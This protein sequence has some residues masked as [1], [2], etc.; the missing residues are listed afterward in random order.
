MLSLLA[1]ARED[2][3]SGLDP[4]SIKDSCLRR[5]DKPSSYLLGIISDYLFL[6]ITF[7]QSDGYFS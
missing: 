6:N 7:L 4:E 2:I 1:N 3:R 5:N